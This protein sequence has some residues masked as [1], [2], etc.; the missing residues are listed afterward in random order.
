MMPFTYNISYGIAFGMI[1]FVAIKLFS[2]KIKETNI[3]TWIVALLFA[4]MF[5]TTH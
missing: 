4:I 5:F 3:G 2:G 1:S